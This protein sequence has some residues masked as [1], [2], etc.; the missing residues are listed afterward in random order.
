MKIL[1]HHRTQA[2]DG[3]AVHIRSLVRA[4]E[5]LGAEVR[6]VALVEKTGDSDPAKGDPAKGDPAKPAQAAEAS[7]DSARSFPWSLVSH[8][9]RFARE[10]A[11]YGYSVPAARRLRRAA[12]EFRPDFIYERYAFGNRAGVK[13]ARELGIPLILEVN[14]PMVH[15]L[16]R[17]RGLSFPRY[18]RRVET[19]IF[20]AADRVAVV[21]QVLGDMLVE[22]GVDPE[23]IFV[24]PNGVHPEHFEGLDRGAARRD[25][26]IEDTTG[27][28]LGFTGY[29]RDWHR[30]DLVIEGLA[31]D[32]ALAGAHLVLVG[33]G[34]VEQEL[35][36]CAE[37]HGVTSRVHFA[38]TRPHHRIPSI[39][40]A[41]DVGLVPA[42]N[43]YASPLK[44]HE[45]MAAGVVPVAPDQ[46]NLREVLTDGED[47]LLFP[48]GDGAALNL[49]LGRLA[50]DGALRGSLGRAAAATVERDDLTWDGNARRVLEVVK[51]LRTGTMSTEAGATS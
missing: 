1:Y 18:A 22:M 20:K 32:E 25:L 51:S 19:E 10:L 38:G 39:L 24:T 29:Y 42:I 13:V 21:T 49:A 36:D 28:I 7:E 6:E 23:R 15:E 45:Y 50:S 17:T 47:A 27:T 12:A 35:R 31:R 40:A 11:E 41:F 46:P 43:P 34:P 33:K 37:A 8:V 3:Q 5:G 44:L 14:S 9:P 4:F 48:P 16:G 26:G 30:L 2:E